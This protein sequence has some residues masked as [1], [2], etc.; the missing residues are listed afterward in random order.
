MTVKVRYPGMEDS[1]TGRSLADATDLEAPF[2]PLVATL[3]NAAWTRAKPL[4][5]VSVRFSGVE[6]A[7]VQMEMFS[8]AEDKKRRL[9]S[10]LDQLNAHGQKS[11]VAHGHQLGR[12]P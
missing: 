7:A 2:Y 9:A 10:V 11:V 8:Q 4:R 5:L 1:S 6:S 3:L 12:K